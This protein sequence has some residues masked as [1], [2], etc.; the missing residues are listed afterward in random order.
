MIS[1]TRTTNSIAAKLFVRSAIAGLCL[2]VSAAYSVANAESVYVYER[3]GGSRLITDHPRSDTGYRLIK[4]YRIKDY[5]E[6]K[7]TSRRPLRPVDSSYD[8]LIAERAA[9]YGVDSA[10]VKAMV[11]IESSFNPH[12]VSTKGAKGLMQL[13]PDTA[14]RYGVTDRGDPH[15][16]LTGGVRYLKDLLAMFSHDVRLAI[17]AYNAGENAVIRYSGVPPFDE[18]RDYVKQV[19]AL[20]KLYSNL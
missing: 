16:N 6:R 4:I 12:A 11:Q 2:G 1:L 10:L 19:L 15:Q 9:S 20:H 17:A 3:D 5:S 13:M 14:Q 18:T 8:S 7:T